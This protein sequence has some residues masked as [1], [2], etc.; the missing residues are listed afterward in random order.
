MTII[1]QVMII[2]NIPMYVCR[3]LDKRALSAPLHTYVHTYV[4]NRQLAN[5]SKCSVSRHRENFSKIWQIQNIFP[6]MNVGNLET[7]LT[8]S[9]CTT[10]QH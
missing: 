2:C 3:Y 6:L 7:T 5:E 1:Y 8:L 10:Q 4:N 9:H